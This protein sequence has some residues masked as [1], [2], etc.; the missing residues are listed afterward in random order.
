MCHKHVDARLTGTGM[1]GTAWQDVC[2]LRRCVRH[3]RHFLSAKQSA[4]CTEKP[5]STPQPPSP[6][7][8]ARLDVVDDCV[9]AAA[10]IISS[11]P[12]RTHG[13]HCSRGWHLS[14]NTA[15]ELAELGAPSLC[16]MAPMAR[17]VLLGAEIVMDNK[18]ALV[19]TR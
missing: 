6:C 8:V 18:R 17:S 13:T 10:V 11:H 3:T 12:W 9:A 16:L 1:V 19:W 2:S 4:R 14:I 15:G 5:D 7:C